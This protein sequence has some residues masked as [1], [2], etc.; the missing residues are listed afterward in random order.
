M[1]RSSSDAPSGDGISSDTHRAPGGGAAA[2]PASKTGDASGGDGALLGSV[3]SGLVSVF[4]LQ[5]VSRVLTFGLNIAIA[6]SV[7]RKAYGVGSVQLQLV[8]D[9]VLA[10][11]REGFR[12]ACQRTP[13]SDW[14]SATRRA[15]EIG[16]AHV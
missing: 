2:E 7:D 8:C 15:R 11:S 3:A 4:S 14:H 12:D 1:P 13:T 9:A 10:L 6:R 16:R 5:L